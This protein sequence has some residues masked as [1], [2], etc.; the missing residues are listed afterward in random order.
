[1]SD[2]PNINTLYFQPAGI[3]IAV[4]NMLNDITFEFQP[5]KGKYA[6]ESSARASV[7]SNHK[8][9][10]TA[11]NLETSLVIVQPC[12]QA[13]LHE[14]HASIK[15]ECF[16]TLLF[17]CVLAFHSIQYILIISRLMN[18]GKS[19]ISKRVPDRLDMCPTH[20]SRRRNPNAG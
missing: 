1:M 11:H 15:E 18:Y 9:P 19:P 8:L 13:Y 6:A 20:R 2:T 5:M 16:L 12:Q 4:K 14:P 7:C 17:N 10:L 3:W